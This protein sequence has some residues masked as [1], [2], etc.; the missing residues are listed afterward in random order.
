MKFRAH[1]Y[2]DS[3]CR[4]QALALQAALRRHFGHLAEVRELVDAG[5][6]PHLWP[7]F[8]V[9]FDEADRAPLEHF[10][11]DYHGRLPI[12]IRSVT[13][14]RLGDFGHRSAWIGQELPLDWIRV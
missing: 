6:G 13:A 10:F 2:F 8:D 7:H 12:L 4:R 1:V 5:K 11:F 9:C 14:D 3:T